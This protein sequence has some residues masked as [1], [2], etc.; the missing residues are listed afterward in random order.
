[1][2]SSLSSSF[3]LRTCK[4]DVFAF[5][6]DAYRPLFNDAAKALLFGLDF[7][8]PLDGA[9]LEAS[10]LEETKLPTKRGA[11]MMVMHMLR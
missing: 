11:K 1:M 2:S 7:A 4:D 10:M 6:Y 3:M 8:F 5:E 9:P